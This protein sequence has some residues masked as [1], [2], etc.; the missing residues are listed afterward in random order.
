MLMMCSVMCDVWE[1][2]VMLMMCSVMCD[3]CGSIT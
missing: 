3:V 2:H 1:H